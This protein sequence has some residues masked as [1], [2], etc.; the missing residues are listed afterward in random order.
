MV[1]FADVEAAGLRLAGHIERTPVITNQGLDALVGASVYLKAECSQVTGSFKFRGASNA[2]A[3]L[4][5]EERRAGVVAYSS[6]N[7][8]QAVAR[9]AQLAGSSAVVV[10]PADAPMQKLAAT[11]A[12]GA[13]IVRYDRY[14]QDR[15]ELARQIAADEGRT[16][17]PPYDYE[18][19]IAGQGTVALE[20]HEQV[21]GH[22]AAAVQADQSD[23]RTQ[24]GLGPGRRAAS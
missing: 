5:E 14:R 18:P 4:S 13:R 17:I 16:I 8:G 23:D 15:V 11:E 1:T 3:R 19:V 6:G 12:A 21:P 20:L 10:M 9:A 22:H 24:W 2:I 7:H